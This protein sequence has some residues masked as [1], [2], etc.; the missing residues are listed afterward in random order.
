MAATILIVDDE[1]GILD[2]LELVLED[3][4]YQVLRAGNATEA[5]AALERERPD[6]LLLDNMMPG[7]SGAALMEHARARLGWAVPV[8]L[9]S[10]APPGPLHPPPSAYLPKPFDLDAPLALAADLLPAP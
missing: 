3:E 10:A 8:I 6:L 2:L 4:G 1:V 5:L 7:M 9:M